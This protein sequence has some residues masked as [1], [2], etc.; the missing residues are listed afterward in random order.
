MLICRYEDDPVIGHRLYREIRQVERMKVKGK[1]VQPIP[2]STYQWETVATN[3]DEF[4]DVSVSYFND[5]IMPAIFRFSLILTVSSLFHYYG[6]FVLFIIIV[7]IC[8][9]RHW[10][11]LIKELSTTHIPSFLCLLI[12]LGC[13]YLL[14]YP[15][16]TN[17]PLR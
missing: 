16:I 6:Y 3:L 12:S 11:K 1:N 17:F 7:I 10:N 13:W 9:G 4:Q 8:F 5:S 15:L 2:S 14:K